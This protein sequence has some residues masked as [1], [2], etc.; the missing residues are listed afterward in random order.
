MPPARSPAV[1]LQRRKALV[2]LVLLFP[3]VLLILFVISPP[4]SI[5]AVSNAALR[6][7]RTCDYAAGG[8]VPDASADSQ[9]RYDHTC[10]EIFKG[11]N[12][13]AN[14]K[15]NGRALLRWRWKP[16]GCELLPRLDPH[17]FLERHRNT[18]IGSYPIPFGCVLYQLVYLRCHSMCKVLL[19]MSLRAYWLVWLYIQEVFD[20][21]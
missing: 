20:K 15:R 12:C 8:W 13:I 6:P 11:W 14:G 9:L 7:Q 3:L 2:P 1:R 21:M 17:Q 19:G 4:H 18:N 10:K 16:A 5:P